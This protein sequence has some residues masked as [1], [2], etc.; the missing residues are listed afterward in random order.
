MIHGYLFPTNDVILACS[1]LGL[2]RFHFP[3]DLCTCFNKRARQFY[4]SCIKL[5]KILG[6]VKGHASVEINL[7]SKQDLICHVAKVKVVRSAY[8]MADV[9]LFQRIYY[10][11]R[12]ETFHNTKRKYILH[13][14][15]KIISV[16]LS[17][18]P[19]FKNFWRISISGCVIHGRVEV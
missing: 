2:H 19:C 13:T 10:S 12:I 11:L 4:S 16:T 9:I 18:Y 14:I 15:K 6:K 17:L 5:R 3:S 1:L 7:Q 8:S